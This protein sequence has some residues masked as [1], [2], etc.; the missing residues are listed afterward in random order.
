MEEEE[1]GKKVKG[2]IRRDVRPTP[3][4]YAA[5]YEYTA[6]DE[7]KNEEEQDVVHS[8]SAENDFNYEFDYGFDDDYDEIEEMEPDLAYMYEL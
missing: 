2:G 3:K 4:K 7:G 6:D 5:N 8:P 1:E